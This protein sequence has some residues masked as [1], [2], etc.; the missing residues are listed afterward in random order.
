MSEKGLNTQSYSRSAESED[1][2]HGGERKKAVGK[3]SLTTER[4]PVGMDKERGK[5]LEANHRHI[6]NG[7][8]Y[9]PPAWRMSREKGSKHLLVNR[10]FLA[11]DVGGF[12]ASQRYSTTYNIQKQ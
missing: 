7:Q 1:G 8:H 4:V 2:E 9:G 6:V 12:A 10:R 3:L 5:E 11:E